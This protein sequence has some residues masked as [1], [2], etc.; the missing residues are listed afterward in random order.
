MT[1]TSVY[2]EALLNTKN[3]QRRELLSP[4]DVANDLGRAKST[5]IRWLE[6]GFLPGR[7]RLSRWY[8]TRVELDE[9]KRGNPAPAAVAQ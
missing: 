5:I 3:A 2:R 4:Q 1:D 6:S 9:W 7:R 8:T